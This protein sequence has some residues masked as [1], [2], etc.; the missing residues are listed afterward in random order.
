MP[1]PDSQPS[2]M[3]YNAGNLQNVYSF[4][5]EQIADFKQQFDQYD[6]DKSGTVECVPRPPPAPDA[7]RAPTPPDPADP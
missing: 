1:S 7:Q 5:K 4:T 3:A 2:K 6:E